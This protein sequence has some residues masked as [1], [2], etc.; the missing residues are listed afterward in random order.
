MHFGAPWVL[1]L[2]WAAPVF[3][4]L[5]WALHRRGCRR[6]ERLVDGPLRAKLCP[7]PRPWRFRLQFAAAALGLLLGLL[8]AVGPRWG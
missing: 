7:A 5:L 8:A 4:A 6:V 2:L 3:A 1:F